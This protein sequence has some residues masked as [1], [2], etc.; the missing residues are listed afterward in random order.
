MRLQKTE[1]IE[2]KAF[3]EQFDGKLTEL[4]ILME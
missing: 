1:R 3:I 2:K 4:I